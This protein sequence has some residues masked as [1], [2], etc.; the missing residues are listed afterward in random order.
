M[1]NCT[2]CG[3]PTTGKMKYCDDCRDTSAPWR[4]HDANLLVACDHLKIQVPVVIR[5]SATRKLLGRY[6]GIQLR[7]DA[8]R[9]MDVIATMTDDELNSFMYHKITASARMTPESAS[10]TLWHELTHAAQYERDSDYYISEYAKELQD[11][12]DIAASGLMTFEKAYRLISF[13]VEAKANEDL[14]YTLCP[15]TL[16]NKRAN[17]PQL[18]RP[19]GRIDHVVNGVI[20]NG[21]HA[22]EFEA[23]SR[24]TIEVAKQIRA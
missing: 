22:D 8:P 21:Y 6:H 3:S 15:L 17:M 9:D 5:R 18:K 24:K 23:W 16:V 12:K 7:E 19:H 10:R 13:E 14:H 2:S 11:A 1:R 4:V 20:H